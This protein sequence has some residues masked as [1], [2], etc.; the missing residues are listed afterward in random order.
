MPEY[1]PFEVSQ[2]EDTVMRNDFDGRIDVVPVSDPN[3]PSA[4]HKMM[5][6]Q[7]ALQMAQQAPAGMYNTEELH[8]TER[9]IA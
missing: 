2:G 4:A 1:Y 9:V 5:M 6:A 8:K 3:I 7:M